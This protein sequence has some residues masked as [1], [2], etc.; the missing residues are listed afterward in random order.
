MSN[1]GE[2]K[3][4]V[5]Q[6]GFNKNTT[7]VDSEGKWVDGNNVRFRYGKAEKIGGWVR[8]VATQESTP[9]VDTFTGTARTALAW[10][11]LDDDSLLGIAT[12]EKVEIFSNGEYYDM[13]PIVLSTTGVIFTTSAGSNIVQVSSA[14]H[15]SKAGDRV[16]YTSAST[17]ASIGGVP[18]L[19]EF[20]I[21]EVTG[22][23]TY[24]VIMTTATATTVGAT[25]TANYLYP[26]GNDGNG[27]TGGWGSDEWAT[28]A[29]GEVGTGSIE[30]G[31]RQWSLE[32]WGEDLLAN[33]NG[34]GIYT[35]DADTSLD[36]ILV[37]RSDVRM[38]LIATA[39]LE[40]GS[41]LTGSPTRHLIALGCT[42]YATSVFDP[43]V[44]RWSHSEDFTIWDP[45]TS[46]ASTN[47]SGDKR[48]RGGNKIIGGL[49]SK[50][51]NIIFTD[52][53]VHS[54]KWI[55]NP[56][57]YSF[58]KVG[59]NAGICSQHAA[60]DVDST[61]YW[62]ART[63]FFRYNGKMSSMNCTLQKAIFTAG[64]PETLNLD[65]KE[66]VYAGTNSEFN[67]ILWFYPAGGSEECNRYVAYNYLE[68]I[69]YDGAMDRTV[70]LDQGIY[71]VP[72]G[73]GTD[74]TL[75]GHETGKDADGSAM[76]A[77]IQSAEIDIATGEQIMFSD[78]FVPDFTLADGKT[79]N[80]TIQTREYPN[81]PNPV[82]KGPYSMNNTT[83]KVSY[84][85]RGR[86]ANI[87]Y[88]TSITGGDFIVGAPRINVMPDGGR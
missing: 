27:T 71:D 20:P 16:I 18:I 54:M 85:T 86:Q 48:I 47:E 82:T 39:P 77:W 41:I 15:N 81:D 23:N 51:E 34:G 25:C 68:D 11:T 40:V 59:K 31:V 26:L 10:N 69:W 62:M 5:F 6:P 50:A 29:W 75:Y 55:G 60:V 64:N 56:F 49:R 8:E 7:D 70:W 12:N 17:A 52:D 83:K 19:G 66:K 28:S 43:M 78:K 38:Q 72:Y 22:A 1:D 67:E 84:R 87:M 63:G 21:N 58:N 74:S 32:N 61:V 37:D 30:V 14:A 13:T 65:Q 35:W 46:T 2:L 3:K 73:F 9:A 4:I 33:P 36:S 76:R 57:I 79:L 45:L 44:I 88:S 24:T 42:D 80:L 53:S